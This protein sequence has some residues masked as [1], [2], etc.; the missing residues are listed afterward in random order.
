MTDNNRTIKEVSDACEKQILPF[1]LATEFE[2]E[3]WHDEE[4]A[5]NMKCMVET[6]KSKGIQLRHREK[7]AALDR[8]V[9]LTQSE[10]D[11]FKNELEIAEEDEVMKTERANDQAADMALQKAEFHR[12]LALFKVTCTEA[13]VA[14]NST[15][16]IRNR[17]METKLQVEKKREQKREFLEV[18]AARMQW[19]GAGVTDVPDSHC[20]LAR[21]NPKEVIANMTSDLPEEYEGLSMKEVLNHS[22]MNRVKLT[23][24]RQYLSNNGWSQNS[25]MKNKPPMVVSRLKRGGNNEIYQNEIARTLSYLTTQEEANLTLLRSPGPSAGLLTP[26]SSS[27]KKRSSSGIFSSGGRPFK[28][29]RRTPNSNSAMP[30]NH[31]GS[32]L[33]SS[34]IGGLD[35]RPEI[36]DASPQISSD[37]FF[38]PLGADVD[39]NNIL[40][41]IME[42]RD[43]QE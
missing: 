39:Y 26:Q 32:A 16:F 9:S 19:W 29:L 20:P 21:K 33:S 40:E 10:V 23:Q 8:D 42:D 30:S 37:G 14:K 38:P 4:V 12:N 3:N 34:A 15:I 35:L 24:L 6:H 17:L 25:L 31:S 5:A 18:E 28:S 13:D 41:S 36:E 11:N 1:I 43:V 22:N 7:G 27:R 2:K